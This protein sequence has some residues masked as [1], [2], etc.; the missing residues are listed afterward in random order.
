MRNF[1]DP[2]SAKAM[3]QVI[4][5]TD[6]TASGKRGSTDRWITDYNAEVGWNHPHYKLHSTV[7]SLVLP[8]QK[9]VLHVVRGA[10]HWH[11]IASRP[12]PLAHFSGVGSLGTR[13][14]MARHDKLTS[15]PFNLL[16]LPTIAVVQRNL[17]SAAN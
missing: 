9:L 17:R 2:L 5:A 6:Y 15:F 12:D 11:G 1:R 16:F 4:C 14:G 7:I 13:L 8:S 10:W 3:V